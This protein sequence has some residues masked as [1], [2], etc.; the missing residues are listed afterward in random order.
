MSGEFEAAGALTTAGL[1]AGAIEGRESRE[2]GEGACLNCGATLTGPYC[3]QCGQAAHAHRTLA[4][5]LSEFM[6]GLWNFDTKVWR[7][8]PLLI[9][10]PGT[11]TRN[12]V[13]GKRV[14]YLS[15]L[16]MFLLTIFAMF[17][18]FAST[19]TQIGRVESNRGLE[20]A[21][22]ELRQEGVVISAD[23]E[24]A[25]ATE[26]TPAEGA[27]A[28]T[29][30]ATERAVAS[31]DAQTR[32][33]ARTWQEEVREAAESGKL[34]SDTGFAVFD[35][36][37]QQSLM[38]PDLALYKVQEAASKYSFLLVPL[39]LPFM[40][41]L[42][43]WKRGTTLY[44]HVVFTLYS[45]CFASIAFM[46]IAISGRLN[47]EFAGAMIFVF[48]IPV[49]TFFHLKGAYA[50]GWWSALWR[51]SFLLLFSIVVLSLFLVA[52]LFLGLLG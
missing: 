19:P 44:D 11:L 31:S 24:P 25:P 50:L 1:A 42:F 26:A 47:A 9:V 33:T 37:I 29:T 36:R 21:R 5:V 7:T 46:A 4:H 30:D 51:T 2:P 3:S 34:R 45:L 13:Y 15:P 38:N 22:A 16:A 20:H 6:Q 39:A 52:I 10:R 8:L 48:G 14:R 41:L 12:Y 18:V 28:P 49:H 23:D 35:Q 27:P 43:I 40:W 17:F 32:D